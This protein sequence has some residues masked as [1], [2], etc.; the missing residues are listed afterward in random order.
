[1]KEKKQNRRYFI[2]SA[3]IGIVVGI[4]VLWDKMVLT[5]EKINSNK[6]VTFP[7]P[8]N[9]EISF[10]GDFILVNKDSEV[11]VYSSRCTHLG[12]KI[13]Q[14]SNNQLLCPCHGSTFGLDGIPTKGP[15]VL[16]LKKMKF[17]IDKLSD[18]ITITT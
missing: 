3:M 1:M 2:K 13:N 15:A 16:P 9:K 12:C 8:T 14:H 11:N 17:E 4:A 10:Q 5:Q 18:M 7:F 6:I